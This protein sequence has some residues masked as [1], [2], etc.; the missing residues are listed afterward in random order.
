MLKDC[1][2]V[3]Y[4]SLTALSAAEEVEGGLA[5]TFTHRN[6]ETKKV[7]KCT[8]AEAT[9]AVHALRQHQAKLMLRR[10]IQ[11]HKQKQLL[12]IAFDI[13]DESGDGIIDLHELGLLLATLGETLTGA[14]LRSRAKTLDQDGN[15]TLEFSEFADVMVKWQEEEL[16]DV[17]AFFD[18]DASGSICVSEL[19]T[20]IQALGENGLTPEEAD[21][22][23]ARV[24]S[25][26][27]GLIDADEFCVFMKPM[28]AITQRHSYKV[29]READNAEVSLSI[30]A[31]GVQLTDS[32]STLSYS[33]FKLV[34]MVETPTGVL[35]TILHR[36]AEYKLA[37]ATNSA[38]IIVATLVQHQSKLSLRQD[39]QKH[40]QTL[41]LRAV[42]NL[43][44]TTR[45]GTID[46]LE[47]TSLL[48][49]LGQSLAPA[50]IEHKIKEFDQGLTGDISF[51]EFSMWMKDNQEKELLDSFAYFDRNSSGTISTVELTQMV[52]SMG[53]RMTQEEVQKLAENVDSDNSGE[54][55]SDEFCVLLRPMLSLTDCASFAVKR[56][57]SAVKLTVSGLGIEISHNDATTTM[58]SFAKLAD[59]EAWEASNTQAAGLSLA[60]KTRD[61]NLSLL[62]FETDDG[63]EIVFAIKK[64]NGKLS[65]RSAIARSQEPTDASLATVLVILRAEPSQRTDKQ[66]A[67]VRK[68]L[69]DMELFEIMELTSELQQNGCCRFL[70]VETYEAGDTVFEEKALAYNI[71]HIVD[72]VV[73]VRKSG[74]EV[75]Q[76]WKGA[77]FGALT[78]AGELIA[79]RTPGIVAFSNLVLIKLSRA[80]YLRICGSL[81]IEVIQVLGKPK[82]ERT[83]PDLQIVRGLFQETALFRMLYYSALQQSC[84][85]GMSIENFKANET[86]VKEGDTDDVLRIMVKG[87][88]DATVA[89]KTRK[90]A[91]AVGDSI[92]F[93]CV[94]GMS[95]V[96][97]LQ[98]NTVVATADCVFATLA[99]DE[100]IHVNVEIGESAVAI[101]EK[102]FFQRSDEDINQVLT[103]FDHLPFI[104][105]LRSK[106]LQQHCC[107]FMSVQRLQ[108]KQVLYKQGDMGDRMY[109]VLNGS[110]KVEKWRGSSNQR[111][112]AGSRGELAACRIGMSFGENSLTATTEFGQRR[113][114]TVSANESTIVAA[115]TRENYLQITRTSELQGHIND[116]WEMIM[117]DA[118]GDERSDLTEFC[119]EGLYT[120]LHLSIAKSVHDEWSPGE[121]LD[122]VKSDWLKD[123]SRHNLGA[124]VLNHRQFSDALFELVDQWCGTIS[125]DLY[126][127]F[128]Q[129]VYLNVREFWKHEE[130]DRSPKFS[131]RGSSGRTQW[132]DQSVDNRG[133]RF[134]IAD[135]ENIK[136]ISAEMQELQDEGAKLKKVETKD[137]AKMYA[138]R[139]K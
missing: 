68:Y 12:R 3:Q 36:N 62:F 96:D 104:E 66:L 4:H 43:F 54:I 90:R 117:N 85:R 25:D 102:T 99:R 72:G 6:T 108:P 129:K 135:L 112:T 91:L 81:D 39:I 64:Q 123:I 124:D 75:R 80:D 95:D 76:Q 121:A 50:E 136:S 89:G 131:K 93:S 51:E 21:A 29:L 34:S 139:R 88:C 20:A 11:R 35:L 45:D 133:D 92:G 106:L 125:M 24:D 120:K 2:Y 111:Q 73:S 60:V 110:L 87:S 127:G 63:E 138:P 58:Y 14:E 86:I 15:G 126:S 78:V 7:F 77:S 33:F 19:S 48:E 18:D 101:L 82:E 98:A 83:D 47:L 115:L 107:R 134:K 57:G 65:L 16:R 27:S 97:R 28:M 84:A 52:R 38:A 32:H 13:V 53:E 37:F 23:A 118:Y 56:D 79:E 40:K 61:G 30:S 109:I 26:G 94:L 69:Q 10:D 119:D 137:M 5:V 49:T 17:F 44:D 71:Y 116:Y 41:Q 59:F 1:L 105:R 22:R 42:F 122:E 8:V 74:Q 132:D 46:V 31:L 128:L 67:M 114:T 100:F 113:E 70:K 9:G 130:G 103:L 55:D